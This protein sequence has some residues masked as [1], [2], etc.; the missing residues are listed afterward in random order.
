MG[1]QPLRIPGRQKHARVYGVMKRSFQVAAK[2]GY[3]FPALLEFVHKDGLA[4]G[5]LIGQCRDVI[6]PFEK[7]M[8]VV[9][10]TSSQRLGWSALRSNAGKSGPREMDH[11]NLHPVS[12]KGGSSSPADFV[13]RPVVSFPMYR[14]KRKPDRSARSVLQNR[15]PARTYPIH[16]LCKS[17][18]A[19]S[20]GQAASRGQAGTTRR[21]DRAGI[22]GG[23]VRQLRID[24]LV[25]C[26]AAVTPEARAKFLAAAQTD[27]K[28]T[29][30][31]NAGTVEIRRRAF[32]SKY[33]GPAPELATDLSAGCHQFEIFFGKLAGD[34]SGQ[35]QVNYILR[36]LYQLD[37]NTLWGFDTFLP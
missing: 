35:R 25:C 2:G 34:F 31:F 24:P 33:V 10:E 36:I 22:G 7:Q 5:V 32:S 30:R 27:C 18:Q 17:G 20:L 3:G 13:K 12:R 11:G 23:Q 16:S 15:N 8:F 37:L 21:L 6:L 28:I 19:S 26:P 9:G 1:R 14:E 4:L 29:P